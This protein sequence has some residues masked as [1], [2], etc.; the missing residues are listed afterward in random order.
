MPLF[1]RRSVKPPP[2]T[3]RYSNDKAL[4]HGTQVN[5]S[6]QAVQPRLQFPLHF[7]LLMRELF[8]QGDA[9]DHWQVIAGDEVRLDEGGMDVEFTMLHISTNQ[10]SRRRVNVQQGKLVSIT[11]C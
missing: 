9:P 4:P 11:D 5:P 6:S 3:A 7:D 10:V 2:Q 1:P 8:I